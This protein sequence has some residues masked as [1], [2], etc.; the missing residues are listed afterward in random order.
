M[1][2]S[3]EGLRVVFALMIFFHHFTKP[4]YAPFGAC[5]VV[6]FF[7]MSGF[8]MTA[9]YHSKI[10]ETSFSYKS[11]IKKRISKIYP[12]HFLGIVLALSVF[13]VKELIEGEL[14]YGKFLYA[15]PSL[16]MVQSFIPC[17]KIFWGGNAVAWFLS[18]MFFFYLI[19]PFVCRT[20]LKYNFRK[21]VIP[22]LSI[23]LVLYFI[24][25]LIIPSKLV[26]SLVYINPFFRMFDFVLG[27]LL[28]KIYISLSG[29]EI[30]SQSKYVAFKRFFGI[31]VWC[32]VA[33][34]ILCSEIVDC[35]FSLASLFWLPIALLLLFYA[36]VDRRDKDLMI[37]KLSGGGKFTYD[38]YVI[39]GSF[40]VIFMFF[41]SFENWSFYF[42]ISSVLMIVIISLVA[43]IIHYFYNPV[44]NKFFTKICKLIMLS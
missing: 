41:F 11:Y 5:A 16:F 22:V 18:D 17:E 30:K 24:T 6:A 29:K 34:S 1:I 40:I 4:G 38:F 42:F 43:I 7:M 37:S 10:E 28:Y 14:H 32:L 35:R 15:I 36:L 44:A 25:V 9:G 20:I 39:H 31:F 8:V 21:T 26:H 27:V 3:I 19:F 2:K 13:V 12:L 23:V 33:T